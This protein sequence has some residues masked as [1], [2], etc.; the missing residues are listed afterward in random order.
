[1]K[2]RLERCITGPLHVRANSDT[3]VELADCIVDAAATDG[4]A[5][6]ADAAGAAGAGVSLEECTVLGTGHAGLLRRA[7]NC[8]FTVTLRAV[9]RQ[10]RCRLLSFVAAESTAPLRHKWQPD[11]AHPHALPEFTSTRFADPGY[12]QR[13]LATARV[14]RE[15]AADGG[16]MG[17]MHALFQPQRE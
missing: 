4:F 15:G 7:S 17:V 6:A 14:I 10:E 16:E 8:I 2:L 9:R 13:R 1:T 3:T 11:A 12:C 5:Y